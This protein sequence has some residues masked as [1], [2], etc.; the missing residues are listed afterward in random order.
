MANNKTSPRKVPHM[1]TS[2]PAGQKSTEDTLLESF[3]ELI[4]SAAEKMSDKEFK[5]A[6]KRSN[7]ILDRAL[8][9]PKRRRETA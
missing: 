6:E 3:G 5:K 7:E 1:A 4:D 9:Q 2:T 8:A